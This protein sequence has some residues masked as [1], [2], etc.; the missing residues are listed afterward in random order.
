MVS[1]TSRTGILIQ[2]IQERYFGERLK[3][4]ERD[5]NKKSSL[6]LGSFSSSSL[7]RGNITTVWGGM[8]NA[9]HYSR[10]NTNVTMHVIHFPE[11][12][13][14]CRSLSFFPE[15]PCAVCLP[16]N[17]ITVCVTHRPVWGA[18]ENWDLDPGICFC[19]STLHIV[20]L[21]KLWLN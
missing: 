17:S 15:G 5:R 20:G 13:S 19:H 12:G 16:S 4:M 18:L 1:K 11:M 3:C 10:S 7:Y 14:P 2:E 8:R 6:F 9:T 21:Q